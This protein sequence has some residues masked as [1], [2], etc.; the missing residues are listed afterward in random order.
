MAY[1]SVWDVATLSELSRVGW[2]HAVN[3]GPGDGAGRMIPCFERAICALAFSP[4]G[5][6][7]LA[8]GTCAQS[9]GNARLRHQH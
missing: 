8:C 4:D 3:G 6:Q 7:L 1:A 5:N 9:A 2:S